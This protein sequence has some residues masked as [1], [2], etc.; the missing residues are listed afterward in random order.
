MCNTIHF[1]AKKLVLVAD[2][3]GKSCKTPASLIIYFFVASF[4][5]LTFHFMSPVVPIP[6][7]IENLSLF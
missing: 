5:L 4:S 6:T 7:A 2:S 3:E 1:H